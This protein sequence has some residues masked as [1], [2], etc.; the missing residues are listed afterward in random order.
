M[1]IEFFPGISHNITHIR[2]IEEVRGEKTTRFVYR[3]TPGEPPDSYIMNVS[4]AE[5]MRKIYEKTDLS[6]IAEMAFAQQE[7]CSVPIQC[8]CTECGMSGGH[9]PNCPNNPAKSQLRRSGEGSSRR[10][11]RGK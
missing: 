7:A 2:R 9:A 10:R 11:K 8:W 1:W 4:Y 3:P 6:K 5:V